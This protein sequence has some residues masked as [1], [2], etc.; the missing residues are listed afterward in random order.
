MAEAN[1]IDFPATRRRVPGGGAALA[2]APFH[3]TIPSPVG[4]LTVY[5][6]DTHVTAV[7]FGEPAAD[8]STVPPVLRRAAAQLDEYFAGKRRHFSVP[9][10]MPGINPESFTARARTHLLDIP[11]GD[12]WTYGDLAAACGSPGAARAAGSACAM[13]PVPIIVPCHR[14][15]PA[16]GGIGNYSGG[17]GDGR[18]IKRWLLEHERLN[19]ESSIPVQ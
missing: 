16:S 11:F 14:I 3:T 19:R 18:K 12:T 7:I 5:A 2:D 1:E 15:V 4:A 17:Q 10:A 9:V 6:T 8:N 13:N